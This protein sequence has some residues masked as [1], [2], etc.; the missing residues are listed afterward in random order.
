MGDVL[1][2]IDKA[3]ELYDEKKAEELEKKLATQ[4]FT[5]D[6]FLDQLQQIKKMGGIGGLLKLLPGCRTD[7]GRRHRRKAARKGRGDHT[8][9][10]KT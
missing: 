6:D 3:V 8:I 4:T 9:H 7:Q 2:L 5:L 10:D 1:T